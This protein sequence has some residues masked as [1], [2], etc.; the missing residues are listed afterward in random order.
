[1]NQ[2]NTPHRSNTT[3]LISAL[4]VLACEIES[5]DGVANAAIAEAAERLEEMRGLLRQAQAR[6]GE[7]YLWSPELQHAVDRATS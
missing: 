5:P 4:G 3:T 2:K 1:M 6:Q 7:G